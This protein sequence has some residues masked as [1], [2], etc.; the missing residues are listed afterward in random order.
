MSSGGGGG[1]C[2][3]PG[4]RVPPGGRCRSCGKLFF[5][6]NKERARA[7]C[8]CWAE[9]R[10]GGPAP[11]SPGEQPGDRCSSCGK[12]YIT[13]TTGNGC[14]CNGEPLRYD[15]GSICFT[16]EDR[17]P[18]CGKLIV[19]DAHRT[20]LFWNTPY[21]L[22]V[23]KACGEVFEEWH[24]SPETAEI[25]GPRR[26]AYWIHGKP[27]VMV[28]EGPDEGMWTACSDYRVNRDGETYSQWVCQRYNYDPCD[29]DYMREISS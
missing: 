1:G 16:T 2:T 7:S 29:E 14:R 3:I 5:S 13:T 28:F 26:T 10:T 9:W 12:L 17:C 18:Q 19:S 22:Y 24:P 25:E 21:N 8:Q 23:G 15:D 20:F 11:D 4:S 27:M 6:K